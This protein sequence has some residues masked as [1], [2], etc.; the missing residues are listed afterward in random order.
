M[1]E[2]AE[3]V[4]VDLAQHVARG[5]RLVA[6]ADSG[7]QVHQLAELAIG[8]LGAG[9]ALVEDAPEARVLLLDQH[10]GVV[11]ALA[12]VGL[13]GT[14]PQHLP[15]RPFRHPEHIDLAVIVALL[16]L[17]GQELGIG[18]VQVVVVALIGEAALKPFAARL[19]GVGDVI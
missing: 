13:F 6:K 9:E 14:G 11:D 15:A 4:F 5:A 1:R 3:E 2:L 8:Q 7:D 10:Q 16:Q 17:L 12:D 19:E 18:V